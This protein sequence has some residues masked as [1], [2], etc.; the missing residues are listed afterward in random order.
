MYEWGTKKI[1]LR[2]ISSKHK[3]GKGKTV[4]QQESNKSSEHFVFFYNAVKICQTLYCKKTAK[5][6]GAR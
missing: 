5:A 4:F 3:L 1:T 2:I 6:R